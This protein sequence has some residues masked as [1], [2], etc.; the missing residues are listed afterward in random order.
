MPHP[1]AGGPSC[2]TA[3]ANTAYFRTGSA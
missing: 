3:C 2:V 1:P